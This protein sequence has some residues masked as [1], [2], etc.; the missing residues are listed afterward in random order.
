MSPG[1]AK[2][3]TVDAVQLSLH[4]VFGS[5][6]R[7]SEVENRSKA[8]A[9]GP[10]LTC[11]QSHVCSD[12]MHV[13]SQPSELYWSCGQKKRCF[14][15]VPSSV[16]VRNMGMLVWPGRNIHGISINRSYIKICCS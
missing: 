12:R 8:C 2:F 4:L 1:P 10:H 9:R 15:P 3:Q 16:Q 7:V 14:N 5:E 13:T 6:L 11:V